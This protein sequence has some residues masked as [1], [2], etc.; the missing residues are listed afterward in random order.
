M[1]FQAMSDVSQSDVLQILSD[2]QVVRDESLEGVSRRLPENR[3]AINGLYDRIPSLKKHL[4]Y[5]DLIPIQRA[6]IQDELG[7]ASRL[8]NRAEHILKERAR[9][10][11]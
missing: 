4:S 10:A 5:R 6:A 3:N 8:L 11:P 2:T 7:E 1:R 9:S